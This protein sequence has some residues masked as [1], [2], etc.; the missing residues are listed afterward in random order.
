MKDKKY[1]VSKTETE[2]EEELTPE[3]FHVLRK[4]GTERPGTSSFNNFDEKGTYVCVGCETALY[5]SDNK[6]DAHCGWPS[7]D[8]AIDEN[9][10]LDVDY[11]IGYER[12]E[13]KCNSC[14]GHLG[15]V[16]NDGPRETTGQRHCLNG[17]ALKFVPEEKI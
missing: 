13:L 8:Q 16:F 6:F 4:A 9:I 5:K 15:H 14:G 2:W 12:T 17:V 3:Q 11:K 7:F 10:E 1:N